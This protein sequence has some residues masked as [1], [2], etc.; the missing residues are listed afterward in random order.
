MKNLLLIHEVIQK[1]NLLIEAC[2]FDTECIIYSASQSLSEF[3]KLLYKKVKSKKPVDHLAFAFHE[4]QY[5]DTVLPLDNKPIFTKVAL[6]DPTLSSWE[7]FVSFMIDFCAKHKVKTIDWFACFL[8]QS[9]DWMYFLDQLEI[10]TGVICRASSDK[11][12]NLKYGGDWILESSNTDIRDIY[13]SDQIY[14][15]PILFSWVFSTPLSDIDKVGLGGAGIA[16]NDKSCWMATASNMLA[17]AGHGTGGGI[18]AKAVSI[19]NQFKEYYY[20]TDFTKIQHRTYT[21]GDRIVQIQN[22]VIATG[23]VKFTITDNEMSV[24]QTV[25]TFNT[26]DSMSTPD[27]NGGTPATVNVPSSPANQIDFTGLTNRTYTLNNTI[28]QIHSA[29]PLDTVAVGLV[30]TTVTGTSM[31]V[32]DTIGV[33]DTNS[34]IYIGETIL[35]GTY[36]TVYTSYAGGWTDTGLTWWLSDT[37][38]A[39]NSPYTVV[40]MYGQKQKRPWANPDGMKI[41]GNYLR[42]SKPVGVS[43]SWSQNGSYYG[44]GGHALTAVGDGDASTTS[45]ALTA[46]PATI[47]MTDSDREPNP[48]TNESNT[49]TF[50]AYTR[51][52]KQ[53][54]GW[55]F[56]YS[57][58][59]TFIKHIVVLS[60][61]TGS[62][63][64]TLVGTQTLVQNFDAA[65]ITQGGVAIDA[66]GIRYVVN[67]GSVAEI[68]RYRTFITC[69]KT[70]W[71]QTTVPTITEQDT[72]GGSKVR[73]L[74]IT[75]TFSTA[76]DYDTPNWEVSVTTE[77]GVTG[78]SN[79]TFTYQNVAFIYPSYSAVAPPVDTTVER[80][81]GETNG[82]NASGGDVIVTYDLYG[83]ANYPTAVTGG[84]SSTSSNIKIGTFKTQHEYKWNKLPTHPTLKL[85]IND[86]S[87]T[88]N[89]IYT[90]IKI[91]NLKIGHS[92]TQLGYETIGG[93]LLT[94]AFGEGA[95]VE[96][97]AFVADSSEILNFSDWLTEVDDTNQPAGFS[98]LTYDLNSTNPTGWDALANYPDGEDYVESTHPISPCVIKGTKIRIPK[99]DIEIEKLRTGDLIINQ[100]EQSIPIEYV[101]RFE[102]SKSARFIKFNKHS[103]A[104]NVPNE[105]LTCIERH[106]FI[107][108]NEIKRAW[109][110]ENGKSIRR[111]S[112]KYKYI[113]HLSFKDTS[114]QYYTNNLL[115][116]SFSKS[117]LQKLIVQN[118]ADN[119][120]TSFPKFTRLRK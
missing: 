53:G 77:L 60:A 107:L 118:N 29:S 7:P 88:G 66:T 101:Y 85:K 83:T 3:K 73:Q 114:T 54:D 69:T 65:A 56:N 110:L 96:G 81:E 113:Y 93:A 104:R 19:Y 35:M 58:V 47:V 15:Y 95:A 44:Y 63:A 50:D 111:I 116:E 11:T 5:P 41:L 13:F 70:G 86:A 21:L 99:G 71:T 30:K 94:K 72:Q 80:D 82:D 117:N 106:G 32:K 105:T 46:N 90:D 64:T 51:N 59:H 39:I 102:V 25:G 67:V 36:A 52:N 6:F 49:Y 26:T 103:I 112:K 34:D 108:Q 48:N 97:I 79:P 115:S 68:S 45:S 76:V 74:D 37:S 23:V 38:H 18:Q 28:I 87:S 89:I 27:I 1:K 12:G 33:F 22:E 42:E 14:L 98:L 61:S 31:S 84:S 55:Y 4:T 119:I 120:N 8:L 20:Q 57:S 91:K 62:N 10:K 16:T 40:T 75:W 109:E 43:I 17:S 92:Y 100:Y 78:Q 24:I 9:P 2:N